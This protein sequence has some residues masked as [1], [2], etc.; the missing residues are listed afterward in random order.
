VSIELAEEE[1]D[2]VLQIEDD[3]RGFRLDDPGAAR[4]FGLQGMRE[5][6]D[7]VEAALE[8]TSAPGEGTRVRLRV[9][10]GGDR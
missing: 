5:R 1:G 9:P 4:G 3:G 7:L 6:A 2:L 8:V 10:S